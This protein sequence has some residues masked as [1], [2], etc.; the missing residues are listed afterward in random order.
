MT[1]AGLREVLESAIWAAAKD[2]AGCRK[3]G[4]CKSCATSIDTA[5]AAA[6]AYARAKADEEARALRQSVA[7]H[8]YTG[9]PS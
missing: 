6:D 7:A 8:G 3:H 5:L 4:R 2:V 9:G 1:A